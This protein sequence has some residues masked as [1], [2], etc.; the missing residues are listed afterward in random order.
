MVG[1][2]ALA[3]YLSQ[4]FVREWW[5]HR[6]NLESHPIADYEVTSPVDG[7]VVYVKNVYKGKVM[8]TKKG[9]VIEEDWVDGQDGVLVG[10][11]MC[12]Y[13]RHFIA[14]PITDFLDDIEHRP[15]TANIPM[16]DLWEYINFYFVGRFVDWFEEKAFDYKLKNEKVIYKYF[17]GVRMMGI[18]DKFVNK[19][20]IPNSVSI[21][22]FLTTRFEKIGHIRRGSQV[23]LFIPMHLIEKSDLAVLVKPNQKVKAGQV[24]WSKK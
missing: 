16:M 13:D 5:F 24:I 20:E 15:T 10:I 2:A 19:I 11:Y 23:D 3:V 12:V 9:R 21:K 14:S 1:G 4:K 6:Q 8:T 18:A 7:T 17:S 22:S